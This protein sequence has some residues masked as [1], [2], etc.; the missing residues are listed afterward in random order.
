MDYINSSWPLAKITADAESIA[1]RV[2]WKNYV[3][4]KNE[5]IELKRYTG[6]FSVGL[7]IKHKRPDYPDHMVFWSFDLEILMKSVETLGY[8]IGK[9]KSIWAWWKVDS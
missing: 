6:I 9:P 7:L 2:L 4:K 1:I 5:I 3:L 8:T